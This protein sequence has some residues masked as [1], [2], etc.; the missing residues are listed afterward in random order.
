MIKKSI[1]T[2]FWLIMVFSPLYCEIY[3][4]HSFGV[5]FLQIKD[6]LNLGIVFNGI[7]LEYRYGLIWKIQDH[8]IIYEPKL[9]VG[10]AF[11]RGITAG[12]LRITPANV[13]WTIPFYDQNGHTIRGGLNFAADYGYQVYPDLNAG[14]VF[15]SSEIGIS[16]IIKY[17][18]QWDN[19]SFAVGL[20]NSLLGFT[21]HT[22]KIEPYFYEFHLLNPTDYFRVPHENMQF[23][24]FNKYNHTNVSFEFTPG[25]D[26]HHSFLYEFDYFGLFYGMRFERLNENL[27]WKVSL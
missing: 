12:Q 14:N 8:E 17:N 15:W 24:S 23:G 25:I 16:P 27:L 21:S 2:L 18:Y 11:N 9:G 5:S 7:Q 26:N 19:K 20:Q 4:S 6:Q 13:S 22:Q 1:F 3:Q 10:I